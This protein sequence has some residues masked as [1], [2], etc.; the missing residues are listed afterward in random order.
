MLRFVFTI[1]KNK[2]MNFGIFGQQ[3]ECMRPFAIRFAP[4]FVSSRYIRDV[5][6]RMKIIEPREQ[7]WTFARW[8]VAFVRS[9][10]EYAP[11]CR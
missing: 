11:L 6:K 9:D 1:R 2:G 10:S 5:R 7:D 3:T 4:S 8:I